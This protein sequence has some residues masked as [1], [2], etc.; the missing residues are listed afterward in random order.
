MNAKA[1]QTPVSK[2][3]RTLLAHAQRPTDLA[4]IL[5]VSDPQ[6]V[7]TA[8]DRGLSSRKVGET[9]FDGRAERLPEDAAVRLDAPGVGQDVLEGTVGI[10]AEWLVE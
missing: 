5:A 6:S 1:R 4:E 3:P 8:H 9:R 2:L 7:V 10:R